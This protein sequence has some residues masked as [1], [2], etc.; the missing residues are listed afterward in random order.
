MAAKT[1]T[2]NMWKTAANGNGAIAPQ[3]VGAI[4]TAFISGARLQQE[5]G[6]VAIDLLTDELTRCGQAL[7]WWNEC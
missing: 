2:A 5:L 1:T 7:V 3:S 4:P 6:C